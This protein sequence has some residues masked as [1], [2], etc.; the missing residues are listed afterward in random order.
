MTEQEMVRII[1][2]PHKR[3]LFENPNY[4]R[5]LRI[6]RNQELTAK[7]LHKRF[8][9]DYEDKKTLTSI[10]RY[11]KKLKKNDLLFVSRQETKRGHLIE[12]YYSRTAQFFIFPEEWADE[13]VID[14]TFE[15][16]SQIY[17]L[18]EEVKTK[19][20]EILHELSEKRGQSF[21]EFYKKYGDELL[22]VEEKYGYSVMTKATHIIHELR[23]FRGNPELLE[24]FF[25]LL[26]G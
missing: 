8:N 6:M 7:E 11:L 26:T 19:V 10:Y 1:E 17:T 25:V 13:R 24:R 20:K 3:E 21:I 18:D 12:S 16:V 9:K 22:E 2:D 5:I 15:L 23:Y 4:S 14:A